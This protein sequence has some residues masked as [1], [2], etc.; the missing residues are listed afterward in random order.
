M[1][2]ME[3]VKCI[4]YWQVIFNDKRIRVYPSLAYSPMNEPI[5]LILSDIKRCIE[6][7]TVGFRL[8][9]E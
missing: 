7:D 8:M 2:D 4:V 1:R 3:P 5:M 9:I 6:T